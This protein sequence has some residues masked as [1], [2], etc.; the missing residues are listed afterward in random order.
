V[1]TAPIRPLIIPVFLAHAGCPHRCVFCNQRAITG[2]GEKIPSGAEIHA[3]V[4]ACRARAGR[5]RAPVQLAFFGGNFLGLS[6]DTVHCLLEA[7][8][9][10]V[11]RGLVDGIRFSTRPDSID[12]GALD[13]LKRFPVSTVEIGAQCLDDHV[14][15]ASGRGHDRRAVETAMSHLKAL[16]VQTGLQLMV[17][18]P[19]ETQPRC[20]ASGRR[21]AAL[22]PDFVRI[23]PTLV[24]AGSPLARLFR[25]GKYRPLSLEAAVERVKQ[26][27]LL[28]CRRR[29]PVIRMGLQASRELDDGAA[30]LAGPY[31]PAFGHLVLS[32]IFLDAAADAIRR[33]ASSCGKI[34]IYVH[35]RNIARMRGL[36]SAN[37]KR[38]QATFAPAAVRIVPDESIGMEALRVDHGPE[39]PVYG[40][41]ATSLDKRP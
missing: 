24:L 20:L 21:A 33:L 8:A 36:N 7:A 16:G 23:Y 34:S 5:E 12:A 14:L 1:K 26:L 31:H 29:I 28:F 4:Q 18:L 40:P 30:V 10:L 35:P 39:H 38:L 22:L 25:A 15:A 19:Q 37:L 6:T 32:A 41:A 3:L 11:E 17:G 9:G 13:I 2:A 27:Y